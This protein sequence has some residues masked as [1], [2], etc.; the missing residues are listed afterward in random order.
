MLSTL[1]VRALAVDIVFVF[2]DSEK[3][4]DGVLRVENNKV[5]SV[6]NIAEKNDIFQLKKIKNARGVWFYKSEDDAEMELEAW[7]AYKES[8]KDGLEMFNVAIDNRGYDTKSMNKDLLWEDWYSFV[9]AF[10]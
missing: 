8:P 3:L 2:N 10:S 9:V 5:V 1:L 6:E 7:K 4:D